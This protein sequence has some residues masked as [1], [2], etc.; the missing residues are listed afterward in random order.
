MFTQAL[1]VNSP[2]DMVFEAGDTYEKSDRGGG[3]DLDCDGGFRGL[4]SGKDDQ[5]PDDVLYLGLEG[6]PLS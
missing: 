5:G 3:D 4:L 6:R 1:A 2:N